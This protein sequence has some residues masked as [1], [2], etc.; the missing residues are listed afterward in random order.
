MQALVRVGVIVLMYVL[1]FYLPL[2][3][4]KMYIVM[5]QP[6]NSHQEPTSS[7]IVTKNIIF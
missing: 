5:S 1:C 2:L 3:W 4:I 6:M 7:V